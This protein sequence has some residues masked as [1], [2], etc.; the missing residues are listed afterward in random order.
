MACRLKEITI[1]TDN[2]RDSIAEINEIW[3]DIASGRLPILFDSENSM[4]KGIS[5]VAKHCNYENS[6]EGSYDLIIMGVPPKFY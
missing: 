1:R 5:L 2:S 6:E 3:N 4:Q